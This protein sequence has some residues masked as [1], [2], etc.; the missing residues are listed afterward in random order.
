MSVCESVLEALNPR[1]TSL[2]GGAHVPTAQKRDRD[3][4]WFVESALDRTRTGSHG[5]NGHHERFRHSP[6]H[7]GAWKLLGA[8]SGSPQLAERSTEASRQKVSQSAEAA[9]RRQALRRSVHGRA[10]ERP[11]AYGFWTTWFSIF[12]ICSLQPPSFLRNASRR[13]CAGILSKPD[14]V[15]SSN[16]PVAV[17][18]R[19]NSTRVGGSPE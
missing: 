6:I 8:S 15:T 10:F 17:F 13:R 11:F 18:S 5:R 4:P 2:A 16:V 12:L 3:T 7:A 19:R 1:R 14:S 9:F